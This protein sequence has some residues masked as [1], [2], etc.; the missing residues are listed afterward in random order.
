MLK[1]ISEPF[2]LRENVIQLIFSLSGRN[3]NWG[4]QFEF[5]GAELFLKAVTNIHCL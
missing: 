1:L 4:R 5:Q 3:G 2:E